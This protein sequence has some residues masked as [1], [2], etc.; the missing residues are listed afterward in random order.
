VRA[1]ADFDVLRD[2]RL[3]ER[4]VAALGG[5]W[6]LLATDWR[7]IK[8]AVDQLGKAP[9]LLAVKEELKNA[10]DAAEGSTL[11]REIAQTIRNATKLEDG[12]ARAKAGGL[13]VLP[14]G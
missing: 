10:L 5:D 14:G 4:I 6:T 13:A 3:L 9:L 8:N 7:I 2:D 11:T 1:V 12:W